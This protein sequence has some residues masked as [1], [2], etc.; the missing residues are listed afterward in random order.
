VVVESDDVPITALQCGAAFEF[1]KEMKKMGEHFSSRV[2]AVVPV[3]LSAHR[4][5][6]LILHEK[7]SFDSLILHNSS[8]LVKDALDAA[9]NLG[10]VAGKWCSL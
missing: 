6:N 2:Y 7:L 1:G 9:M 3:S 5:T 10:V 4:S 8:L